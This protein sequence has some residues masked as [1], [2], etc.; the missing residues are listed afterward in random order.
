VSLDCTPQSFDRG[1]ALLDRLRLESGV[2]NLGIDL[3]VA[4]GILIADECPGHDLRL[5]LAL[6]NAITLAACR[7][8]RKAAV[9]S[10]CAGSA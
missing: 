6:A 2:E 7:L 10:S 9:V 3:A 8:R 4:L 5:P 1:R